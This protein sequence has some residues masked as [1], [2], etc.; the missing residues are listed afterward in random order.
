MVNDG[1]KVFKGFGF[2]R[3]LVVERADSLSEQ[4]GKGSAFDL[5][6]GISR[7]DISIYFV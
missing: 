1:P 5:I 4:V 7:S 6:N 3:L 2:P